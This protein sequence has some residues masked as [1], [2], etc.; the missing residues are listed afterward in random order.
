MSGCGRAPSIV[1]A[2]RS[3]RFVTASFRF[4][5][6]SSTMLTPTKIAAAESAHHQPR[7]MP[8]TPTM[9]ATP[10]CQSALFMSA[11]AYS[12][13]SWSCSASLS[14]LWPRIMG[15]GTDRAITAIMNQ[16]CHTV[17]PNRSNVPMGGCSAVTRPS[18]ESP[19]RTTP[20][21]DRATAATRCPT[22]TDR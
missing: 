1:A 21:T 2:R 10:V 4:F 20:I 9:V 15:P 16:P 14:F 6:P 13:R 11:S 12:T 7:P 18:T 17:C 19:T 5:Q 22:P 3:A 8:A